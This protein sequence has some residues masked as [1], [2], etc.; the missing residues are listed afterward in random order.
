[1][2]GMLGSRLDVFDF[3][4]YQGA[5]LPGPKKDT[6]SYWV[7]IGLS[8]KLCSVFDRHEGNISPLLAACREFLGLLTEK[9]EGVRLPDL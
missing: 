1:M 7:L 5:V 3:L 4:N 9:V 8:Q 6:G 2:I